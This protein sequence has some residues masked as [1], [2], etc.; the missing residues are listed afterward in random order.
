MITPI[1]ILTLACTHPKG[2]DSSLASSEFTTAPKRDSD[3]ALSP[4]NPPSD[5]AAAPMTPQIIA[6]R[7]SP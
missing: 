2:I 5:T 6:Q 7:A 3:R 1:P 4:P